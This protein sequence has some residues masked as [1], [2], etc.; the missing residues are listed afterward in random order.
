VAWVLGSPW[1][2][3]TQLSPKFLNNFQTF[4]VNTVD[5][6]IRYSHVLAGSGPLYSTLFFAFSVCNTNYELQH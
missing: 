5:R 1:T 3:S 4:N 6:S 2:A